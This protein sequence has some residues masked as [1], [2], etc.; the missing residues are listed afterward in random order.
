[1][2]GAAE[3]AFVAHRGE[4]TV[5]YPALHPLGVDDGSPIGVQPPERVPLPRLTSS[6]DVARGTRF[7]RMD[8]QLLLSF[9]LSHGGSI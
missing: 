9:F 2:P 1:M 4:T 8:A 5:A 6:S 3:A 7:G